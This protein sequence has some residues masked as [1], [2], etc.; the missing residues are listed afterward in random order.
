[1]FLIVWFKVFIKTRILACILYSL[2]APLGEFIFPDR[3]KKEKKKKGGKNVG[4]GGQEQLY[5]C[6]RKYKPLY[7]LFF[8]RTEHISKWEVSSHFCHPFCYFSFYQSHNVDEGG[9]VGCRFMKLPVLPH[10]FYC[11]ISTVANYQLH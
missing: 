3:K 5:I 10:Y 6:C 9:N 2:R 8:L 4:T 7:T 11:G 1:M